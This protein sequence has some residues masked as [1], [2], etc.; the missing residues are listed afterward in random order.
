MKRENAF[1][2]SRIDIILAHTASLMAVLGDWLLQQ[3]TA[4][5]LFRQKAISYWLHCM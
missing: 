2:M 4:R 1:K 3:L 5:D